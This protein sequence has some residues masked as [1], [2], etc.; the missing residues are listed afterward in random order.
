MREN[1]KLS[2]QGI[3]SHKMRSMLTMLG[4]IIGIASIIA[5][6]STI[7]GNSEMIKESL[8]GSNNNVVTVSLYDGEWAYDMQYNGNPEGI[9]PLDS[10]FK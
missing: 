7:T 4:I 6:V 1:I 8:I 3:W 9:M 5:I 2:L 10:E